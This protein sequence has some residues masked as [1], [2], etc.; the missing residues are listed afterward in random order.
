MHTKGPSIMKLLI[1]LLVWSAFALA[2]AA[3]TTLPQSY[4]LLEGSYLT[5]DQVQ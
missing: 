3:T 2:E 5:D 1:A 4:R